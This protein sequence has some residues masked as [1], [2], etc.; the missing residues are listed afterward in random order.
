M[1]SI[2]IARI[3]QQSFETHPYRTLAF[4]NGTLNGLGDAVA[5]LSQRIVSQSLHYF[6]SSVDH[7]YVARRETT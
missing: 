3:Y 7:M 1:V 5:Q 6:C 4:T 2:P